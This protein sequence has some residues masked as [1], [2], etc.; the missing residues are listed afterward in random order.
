[1]PASVA[2]A[3]AMPLALLF[4]AFLLPIE[5]RFDLSGLAIYPHRMAF[6]V[7][8]PW[9]LTRRID[10]WHGIDLLLFLAA[11]WMIFSFCLF[12]G[13]Q[14]GVVR[15]TALAFD[16]VS[17]YL[18]ARQSI[19]SLHDLRVLLIL[20]APGL[21]LA[22]LTMAIESITHTNLIRPAVAQIFG[23]LPAYEGGIATGTLAVE[24]ETRL[25]LMRAR[26]PF[27]HSILAGIFLASMLS[28]YLLANLRS[29]PLVTGIGAGIAAIFSV[30]SGAFLALLIVIGLYMYDRIQQWVTFL[31]WRLFVV[32]FLIGLA[33]IQLATQSGVIG[34]LIRLSLNPA[35]GSYRLLI[36]EY[37]LQ[38]IANHPWIGIGFYRL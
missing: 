4:Y 8:L 29:W 24:S 7:L 27:A 33:F 32:V 17:A 37:G 19:R 20:I 5:I 34:I 9:V 12:Y 25:G 35:T 11:A 2:R 28:F 10:K 14:Q 16:V 31:S 22:G 38:S 3:W 6:F 30:S 1:M 36:W 26:G 23:P 18:I 15:G 21:A 13:F